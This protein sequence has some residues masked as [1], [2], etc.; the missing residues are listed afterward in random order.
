M[1]KVRSVIGTI[2]KEELNEGTLKELYEKTEAK[3]G[4]G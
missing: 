1:S 3:F 4:T 2:Y